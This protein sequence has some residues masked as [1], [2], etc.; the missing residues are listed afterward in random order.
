MESKLLFF[1][2]FFNACSNGDEKTVLKYID[3]NEFDIN[4]LD[5]NGNTAFYN[6]CC[7]TRLEENYEISKI[8]IENGADVNFI[9]NGS[10]CF[11]CLC[12]NNN[13][14]IIKLLNE[15]GVDMNAIDNEG[16]TGFNW[17]CYNGCVEVVNLLID[18]GININT[19]DNGG[20]SGFINACIQG[21][22]EIVDILINI[23]YDTNLED[24]YESNGFHYACQEGHLDIIKLLFNKGLISIDTC[25]RP[26]MNRFILYFNHN[27]LVV[28][29]FLIDLGF[30]FNIK[31]TSG[32]SILHYFI[33]NVN[34]NE[35]VVN[36][37]I[38]N[39]LDIN[40]LNIDG[41]SYLYLSC[42]HGNFKFV[43]LLIELKVNINELNNH[44]MS[45]FFIA[46]F[47][48]N[49]D[50][51]LLFIENGFDIC[52][53]NAEGMSGFILAC[54]GSQ[55]EIIKLLISK[56]FDINSI[57]KTARSGLYF[58]VSFGYIDVVLF[59]IKYSINNGINSN[60]YQDY[61]GNK[62]IN[63]Y[64]QFR[65]ET[66]EIEIHMTVE[67]IERDKCIIIDIFNRE[68]NWKRRKEFVI[69]LHC[70]NFFERNDD[71][72]NGI[73]NININNNISTS[74]SDEDDIN[75]ISI[76][77]QEKVLSLR[78]LYETILSFL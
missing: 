52:T 11:H 18:K 36:L 74:T 32:L 48:G 26:G 55:L 33:G 29:K 16:V 14:K 47:K 3:N 70:S 24:N 27:H 5:K 1:T 45:G 54:S 62:M 20:K 38:D 37:L 35:D 63:N 69:F 17:A 7:A 64:G 8:L 41:N 34:F 23:G 65:K 46:C 72:N 4:R 66:E 42:L 77:K 73:N 13:V 22:L 51:V 12:F 57:D 49:I 76:S 75:I 71:I 6:S 53:T 60:I 56:G 59:L 44:G 50:I 67:E 9:K 25:I 15:S 78:P 40:S 39:G 61:N 68:S 19:V 10:S 30:D 31:H 58:A 2:E 28:F 21:H 43:K